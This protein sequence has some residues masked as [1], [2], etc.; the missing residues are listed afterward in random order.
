M[1]SRSS[2]TLPTVISNATLVYW[3][4]ARNHFG[5][6][7]NSIRSMLGAAVCY[8]LI[9]TVSQLH[10]NKNVACLYLYLVLEEKSPNAFALKAAIE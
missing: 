7:I 5:Y 9:L 3:Y 6:L 2:S 10:E 4:T 1:N 8:P